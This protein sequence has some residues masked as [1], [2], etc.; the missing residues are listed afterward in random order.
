MPSDSFAKNT[1]GVAGV[2]LVVAQLS[3]KGYV[4]LPTTRNL[5]SVD[6]VAFNEKLNR[7]AFIQV[8]TTDTPK[9]GWPCHKIRKE[10]GWE[11]DLRHALDLGERFFYVFVSLPTAS[12]PQ[13]AYYVVPSAEVA[14]MI[15]CRAKQWLNG[16]P[17]RKAEGQLCVWEYGGPQK[18]EV[19]A[20]YE[21]KWEFLGL[22]DSTPTA[23]VVRAG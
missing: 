9:R 6:I 13:P 14:E 7:F 19:I 1:K 8:K 22:D 20:K 17:D 16:K 18:A 3:L 12:Q 21:D 11:V 4:A 23:A 2:H 5:K 15:A 10:D